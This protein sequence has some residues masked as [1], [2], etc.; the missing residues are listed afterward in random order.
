MD[1]FRDAIDRAVDPG[2]F[3]TYAEAYDY[4]RS[5]DETILRERGEHER[6]AELA[7]GLFARA[8]PGPDP[9]WARRRRSGA[10]RP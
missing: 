1:A 7:W 6:A 8:R 2:G 4:S 10:R 5:L 9:R 3:V